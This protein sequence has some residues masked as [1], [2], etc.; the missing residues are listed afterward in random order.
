[1]G[2]GE[3]KVAKDGSAGQSETSSRKKSIAA[4]LATLESTLSTPDK[5]LKRAS[6]SASKLK[7]DEDEVVEVIPDKTPKKTEKVGKDL[8]NRLMSKRDTSHLVSALEEKEQARRDAGKMFGGHNEDE[9]KHSKIY[10]ALN[11]DKLWKE[12]RREREMA[13]EDEDEDDIDYKLFM[14]SGDDFGMRIQDADGNIVMEEEVGEEVVPAVLPT[15]DPETEA[16]LAVLRK[17]REEKLKLRQDTLRTKWLKQKEEEERKR[18]EEIKRILE[19]EKKLKK[20]EEVSEDVVK[21]AQ[22]RLAATTDF[23]AFKWSA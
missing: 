20:K 9:E 16:E 23:S 7:E 15:F 5:D 18:Q 10:K 2:G 19:E 6:S 3:S 22:E 17:D 4:S 1:M 8:K 14:R 13:K 11:P 21:E 12:S